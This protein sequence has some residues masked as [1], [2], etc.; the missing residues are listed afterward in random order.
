MKVLVATQYHGLLPFAWRLKKENY[1]VHVL[2]WKDRFEKAWAGMFDKVVVGLGK[3][4]ENLEALAGLAKDGELTVI[5]DSPKGMAVFKEAK[6]LFGILPSNDTGL[7]G[8]VSVGGWF[9]GEGIVP[10]TCHLFFKDTGVLPG[11]LGRR[12]LGGGTLFRLD[13][14]DTCPLLQVLVTGVPSM[15][16]AGFKGLFSVDVA[17]DPE[18]RGLVL[19]Q[20]TAG[21]PWLQTH[22]FVGDLTSLGGLLE[23]KPETLLNQWVTVLPVTVP[24]WPVLSEARSTEEE[25]QGLDSGD[26]NSFFLHDVKVEDGRALVAQTDGLVAVV[27]GSGRFHS[28]SQVKALGLAGKI[29]L[30]DKQFRPD[31]GSQVQSTLAMLELMG[32]FE[33]VEVRGDEGRQNGTPSLTP[34]SPLRAVS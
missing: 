30:T 16:D 21:W 7:G 1:E 22:A 29:G 18:T 32:M 12:L 20:L 6:N 9:D 17:V 3:K 4:R 5:V 25:L 28:S 23:G 10:S 33:G 13:N 14:L 26:L 31:V 15:R 19:G 11:G 8:S 27:R 24:P 2:C 34:S